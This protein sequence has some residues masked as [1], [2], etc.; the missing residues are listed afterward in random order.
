MRTGL[1]LTQ[2][3]NVKMMLKPELQQSL[4][5]LQLSSYE[6]LQYLNEQ[7]VENPVLEVEAQPGWIGERR[8]TIGKAAGESNPLWGMKA[9]GETLESLLLSQLRI[10]RVSGQLYKIAA[11]LAGNL[12][13]AGYLAISVAETASL[14]K[15]PKELVEQALDSLQSLDPAGIG[16][17]SFRECL[18]LQIRR[19]PLALPGAGQV[20]DQYLQLLAEGKLEKIGLL[21]GISLS[22]VKQIAS[23]IRELNPRPW[24]A[25][26]DEEVQYVVPD[27]YLFKENGKCVIQLNQACVPKL[28]LSRDYSEFVV[29]RSDPAAV[30]FL[31]DKMKSANTI[32]HGMKQRQV[33][34]L[35]V[36]QSIFEE[37][38]MFADDGERTLKPL[39]LR[40][41]SEKL[42]IHESTVSRAVQNKYIGTP[43]GIFELKYFF[44]SGLQTKTGDY[45]SMKQIKLRM[46]E[47][48]SQ[49][50]KRQPLSDQKIVDLLTWEG[51]NIARRTVTKYREEMN[52]LSSTLR[53]SM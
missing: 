16:A 45:A 38:A 35:R 8:R 3:L 37:Q 5:I 30:S 4:Q 7:A 53:R 14:L 12:N 47:L 24:S 44:S 48:I 2:Q 25:N 42:Q 27:A 43:F 15:Q 39:T 13:E 49:E 19:D 36:I 18:L 23:Y 32:L 40:I 26:T 52:L 50:N 41:I 11:F 6:L 1:Q 51:I 20:A 31:K 46:K 10:A 28:A 33:T 17:T 21:L 22:E 9:K 34:M 29:H